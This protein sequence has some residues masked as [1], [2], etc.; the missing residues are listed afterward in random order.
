LK[1]KHCNGTGERQYGEG[2]TI[3]VCDYCN[4]TGRRTPN[5]YPENRFG[6]KTCSYCEGSGNEY[7]RMQKGRG[8]VIGFARCSKCGGTGE[9][10]DG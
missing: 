9:V 3:K 10:Q 2:Q 5:T 1:C 7:H 4:G 6:K 8:K